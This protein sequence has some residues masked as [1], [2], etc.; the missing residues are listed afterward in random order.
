MKS[1]CAGPSFAMLRICPCP[2]APPPVKQLQLF[3]LVLLAAAC[4]ST[5]TSTGSSAKRVKTSLLSSVPREK[6]APVRSAE[7]ETKIAREALRNAKRPTKLAAES[8]ELT[9]SEQEVLHGR[10]DAARVSLGVARIENI[11][12]NIDSSNETYLALLNR[13]QG[14]RLRLTVAKREHDVATLREMHAAEE[15]DLAQAELLLARGEAL[16]SRELTPEESVPLEDLIADV[17]FH[18]AEVKIAAGRLDA[19]RQTLEAARSAYEANGETPTL[20]Q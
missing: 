11:D 7:S 1:M 4:A 19:A 10:V 9:R 6:M 8:V 13:T 5:S 12:A 15:Y 3:A 16:E 17:L 14:Q 2:L 20:E 18:R